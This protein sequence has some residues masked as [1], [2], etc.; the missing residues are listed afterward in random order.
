[1]VR[2]VD[3][4]LVYTLKNRRIRSSCKKSDGRA[5]GLTLRVCKSVADGINVMESS[6]KGLLRI[7][8]L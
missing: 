1:M 8:G 5:V 2:V 6:V 3:A 7:G 4:V